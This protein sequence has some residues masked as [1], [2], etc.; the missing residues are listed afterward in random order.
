MICSNESIYKAQDRHNISMYIKE[1]A[2]KLNISVDTLRRWELK[3]DFDIP[4]DSRNRKI[5]SEEHFKLLQNIKDLREQDNGLDTISRK[6]S[7]GNAHDRQSIGKDDSNSTAYPMHTIGINDLRELETSIISKLDIVDN[8][9]EKLSRASFEVGKLQAEKVALEDKLKLIA[10]SS[11][12]DVN[13]LNKEIDK[14]KLD[15][16]LQQEKLNVQIE[17]LQEELKEKSK[18][19]YKK[20]FK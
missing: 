8:L 15:S 10:D 1:V 6:L 7:I 3:L 14:I 18:P 20:L 9:S 11:G 16:Q 5:Y 2:E 19:W 17:K 4:V 12:K 13:N